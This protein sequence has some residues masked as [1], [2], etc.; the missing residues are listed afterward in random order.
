MFL[1]KV[2][3]LSPQI[4]LFYKGDE[5]H[6]S[7]FSGII[8]LIAYIIIFVFGVYYAL[9]FINKENPTAYF[10]NR[11]VEDAGNYPVNA[12]SMFHFIQMMATGKNNSHKYTDFNAITVY[13][14]ELSIDDYMEDN[15]PMLHDHWIY[16]YCNNDS[17][18]KG[19]AHL[20]NHELY[21]QALCIRKYYN[22]EKDTY[23]ETNHENFRWPSIDKGCSHPD[24]TFYG[25][26][27]EKCRNITARKR[28]GYEDCKTE[29]EINDYLFSSSIIIQLIDYYPDV[30][31]YEVPFTKYFYALT[32]GLFK[33]S[34][35]INHLNF[36]P[37][38]M[39]THNGIFFDNQVD[40]QAYIFIQNEKVTLE[41][42]VEKVVDGVTVTQ[43]TGIVVGWYF[44][45]LNTMEYYERN[46]KRLQDILGDIG[47]VSSIVILVAEALNFLASRYALLLDTEELMQILSTE[48]I[49]KLDRVPTIFYK[50][51]KI[52]FPPRRNYYYRNNNPQNNNQRI[53]NYQRVVKPNVVDNNSI[54]ND[55]EQYNNIFNKNGNKNNMINIYM[56]DES[57]FNSNSK[58]NQRRMMN[59]GYIEKSRRNYSTKRNLGTNNELKI[60]ENGYTIN[61]YKD[62]E[63]ENHHHNK[64]SNIS[65]FNF[66]GYLFT[67]GKNSP[68][69][70]YFVNMRE[71][72]ISEENMVQSY[73]DIYKLLKVCKLERTKQNEII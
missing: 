10:F 28:A 46:Y 51:D 2:D 39:K 50:N 66:L 23:Y 17:D 18:T 47:G 40:E 30:L 24:R 15:D 37:A 8:T 67:C 71:Q 22:K 59:K 52:L 45:M 12:S 48:N 64:K 53:I 36:N 69:I 29:E 58:I 1:K 31:N 62:G 38:L 65:F 4:T 57:E 44:W 5:S 14:L 6:S 25:V 73:F 63:K 41:D 13:G 56:E 49:V 21:D 54:K 26:V 19:V 34:I 35:T 7:I 70:S 32:N 16:G 43:K 68:N 72:I 33:D 11:Y 20:V 3:L 55:N 27:L 61:E 42:K 9:E 60:N